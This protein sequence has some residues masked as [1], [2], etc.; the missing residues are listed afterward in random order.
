[1]STNI[2]NNTIPI[3][4]PTTTIPVTVPTTITTVPTTDS[5]DSVSVNINIPSQSDFSFV[6]DNNVK[7]ML[8]TAF[9]AVAS[10]PGGWNALLP[11]PEALRGF[12][13]SIHVPESVLSQIE[14]GISE[15]YEFHSGFSYSW[16]MRQMQ[17]IARLGWD[18]YVTL[19]LNNVAADADADA[20]INANINASATSGDVAETNLP[21]ICT[22]HVYSVLDDNENICPIC[23]DPFG[24]NVYIVSDGIHNGLETDPVTCGHKYHQ[25]CINKW[26]SNRHY[27]CP[28]CRGNIVNLYPTLKVSLC[29]I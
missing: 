11:E 7:E 18:T 10:V 14:K 12:M 1:M 25:K 3:T 8:S 19:Y 9:D 21:S 13:F 28:M 5:T 27:C 24:V 2:N 29:K 20:D 15:R 6:T 17:G 26:I 22:K 23:F 4:V 16:T